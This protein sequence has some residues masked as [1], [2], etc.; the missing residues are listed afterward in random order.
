MICEKCQH[1]VENPKNINVNHWHCLNETAWSE[2]PAVQVLV[3]RLLKQLA[4]ERWAQD[5]MD[6]LYLDE[7]IVQWAESAQ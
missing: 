5:L 4:E 6:Q 1:Q 3:W 7:E 2:V